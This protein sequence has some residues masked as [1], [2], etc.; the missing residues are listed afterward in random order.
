MDKN[1]VLGCENVTV[2]HHNRQE[3][4][5]NA[6]RAS[7]GVAILIKDKLLQ[8][9]DCIIIDKSIDGIL[10]VHFKNRFSGFYPRPVLASGYCHCL[11]PSVRHQLCPCD[12]SSLVQARITKFGP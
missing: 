8:Q 1:A 6:T 5:M 12:N 2:F 7:G 11:R 3:K 4:H 10:G 9:Y